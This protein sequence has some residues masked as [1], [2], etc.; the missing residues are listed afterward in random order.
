MPEQKKKTDKNLSLH[1]LSFEDALKGLLATEP[2]SKEEQE[3]K[4]KPARQRKRSTS[5]KPAE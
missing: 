3:K 2:P 5:K 4:D 1:P